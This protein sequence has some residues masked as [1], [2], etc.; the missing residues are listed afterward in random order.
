MR[1]CLLAVLLIGCGDDGGKAIDAAPKDVLG[2]GV[3]DGTTD[4]PTDAPPLP[5]AA[6]ERVDPCPAT[7][8]ATVITMSAFMYMPVATN[9]TVNQ[10]V[11]FMMDP[12]HDVAPILNTDADLVVPFGQTRCFKFTT[13]GIARFKCT[14]HGFQG[15]VTVN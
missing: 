4:A 7:T 14:P 15:T 9:I 10:T 1:G 6:V 3:T 2:D 5:A 8:D 13:T 11:K 12:T